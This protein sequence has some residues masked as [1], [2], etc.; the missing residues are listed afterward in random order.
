MVLQTPC[1]LRLAY[2]KS[3]GNARSNPNVHV[4][5]VQ[6]TANMQQADG[7]LPMTSI[8]SCDAMI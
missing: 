6:H 3:R 8:T 5:L 7:E 4:V 1:T 2:L